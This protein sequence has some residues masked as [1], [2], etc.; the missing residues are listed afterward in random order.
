MNKSVSMK[1]E[2]LE[3]LMRDMMGESAS[4]IKPKAVSV[5]VVSTKPTV[6]EDHEGLEEVLRD[7]AENEPEELME[8][9][10][11]E[12]ED[13]DKDVNFADFFNRLKSRK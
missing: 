7:A 10:D 1:L 3:M 2:M 4:K 8:D 12:Y 6:E 5:E 9:C 13:E 11:D